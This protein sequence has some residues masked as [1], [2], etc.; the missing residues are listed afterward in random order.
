MLKHR[1]DKQPVPSGQKKAPKG[2]GK[3]TKAGSA[4]LMKGKYCS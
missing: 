4:R 2:G 3:N 1:P